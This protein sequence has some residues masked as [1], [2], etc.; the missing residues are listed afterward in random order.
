MGDHDGRILLEGRADG[1]D[2][3]ALLERRERLQVVAHRDVELVR[4]EQLQR[5]DLRAA[6]ADG[7]VEPVAPI[8]SFGDRLVEAA[9]HGLRE[10]VRAEHE[11]RERLRVQLRGAEQD[12]REKQS[13][14]KGHGVSGRRRSLGLCGNRPVRGLAGAP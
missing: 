2:R 6:H 11:A 12:E 3:Q 9:V 8:D 4:D 1:R 13:G 10:P 7:D 14:G 5:I